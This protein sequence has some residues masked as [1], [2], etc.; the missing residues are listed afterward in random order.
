M[1]S[2]KPQGRAP[3][4]RSVCSRQWPNSCS[5]GC[6]VCGRWRG[7][8]PSVGLSAN[9]INCVTSTRSSIEMNPKL[10]TRYWLTTATVLG[11]LATNIAW[12][13]PQTGTAPST[14]N[15][16]GTK[17]QITRSVFHKI[18]GGNPFFP[19]PPP[20]KDPLRGLTLQGVSGHGNAKLAI[21]NNRT[22]AEGEDGRV[23]RGAQTVHIRCLQIGADF[24]LIET[25]DSAQRGELRLRPGL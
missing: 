22:F 10:Q 6:Y 5:P 8:L 21:I 25:Y 15:P 13:V 14:S 18:E 4:A 7:L 3:P 17:S 19:K 11:I 24:V 16:Q 1:E 20:P 2:S 9:G 12:A 23:A